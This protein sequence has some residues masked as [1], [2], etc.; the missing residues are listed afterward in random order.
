MF[1]TA[2]FDSIYLSDLFI[3]ELANDDGITLFQTNIGV[4]EERQKLLR[5]GQNSENDE[6]IFLIKRDWDREYY[7]DNQTFY[8]AKCT[9]P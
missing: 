9:T 6:M 2:K 8:V 3:A 5:G 7:Q 4:I 1:D